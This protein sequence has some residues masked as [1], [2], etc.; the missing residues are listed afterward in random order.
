MGVNFL[1]LLIFSGLKK[2]IRVKILDWL[3][4]KVVKQSR[5]KYMDLIKQNIFQFTVK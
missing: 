5:L 3:A 2:K 4:T 1:A